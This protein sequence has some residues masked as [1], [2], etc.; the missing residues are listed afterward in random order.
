M[1]QPAVVIVA[2]FIAT[3]PM[4]AQAPE[5]ARLRLVIADQTGAVIPAA[6]V[7]V[8]R[9]S[10]ESIELTSDERGVVV[11]PALD[12]GVA[13]IRVEFLGFE[14]FGG[15]VELRRGS[16]TETITLTVEG[17][18]EEVIVSDATVDDTRG[19]SMSTTL[20]E[21]E[22]DALPDDPEE[23]MAILQDMAG[24]G[25]AT[26]TMDGFRGGRLPT[27]DEIRSIRFR[28]NSFSAENHDAGRTGVD[29]VTRP[30]SDFSGNVNLGLKD[31]ALNARNAMARVETPEGERNVQLGLRGPIVREKT[32][33]RF[34]AQVNSAY[35][36]NTIIA[37]DETGQS[38]GAQVRVP[39]ERR[40]LNANLDHV[41]TSTQMLRLGY[42]H[43]QNDARNQGLGSFDLPE[44]ASSRTSSND[45]VRA[46]VQGLVGR[47]TLNELRLQFN[48][49]QSETVSLTTG[50]TIIV[51]DA[52]SRG[53]AGAGNRHL[54][55][56][57]E[58]AENL[59]FTVRR[60][61]QMRVGVLLEAGRYATVD[62]QN[63]DGRFT[64]A[65]LDAFL[66]GRPLQYTQRIGTVDTA[67][68]QY[69]IGVYWQ[70][71]IRLRRTLSFSVGV[72]QEWQSH[73]GD[74][75]NV[76]P[77][78]GLTWNPQGRRTTL[79]G[80]YG[81]F[82]DWYD[83]NLHDQTLRVNGVAQRDLLIL[84]PGFPDPFAGADPVIL[85]GGRIQADPGLRLPY[86][87]QAS[88]GLERPLV[89]NVDLQVSYQML[90][91]RNQLRARDVN[92]PVDGLRPEPG[93]GTVTQIEST[94][95]SLSD[96]LSVQ[97]RLRA[98]RSRVM[99]SVTYMVGRER[100]HSNGALSLP[101][102]SLDPDVDWGPSGG[103]VRHRLRVQAQVPVVLGMRATVRFAGQS[104]APYTMTTGRD[105]NLDGVV[106][107]RPAGI[108]RNSLRG[109]AFWN[110]SSLRFSRQLTL[111]GARG[112]GSGGAVRSRYSV[113]VFVN[114]SNPLNRVIPQAYSG[115]VL[116]PF[117]Q[118]ATRVQQARRV[119]FGLGFRF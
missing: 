80:G 56:T 68:T 118:R 77:R 87:H 8:T 76:M 47:T 1:R 88:I 57:I 50:P 32:S 60:R 30:S 64:F 99:T 111:G 92:T 112:D 93:V 61:H 85:P 114:A 45:M 7:T 39:T 72:R 23:L 29:I 116:S 62:E 103:D 22:I 12:P 31:D 2:A 42:Q 97:A 79:R 105:D 117:F 98:P 109:E 18:L 110:I 10:G 102:N 106:N 83:S 6:S 107:D 89:R 44:R 9:P 70:D 59:D 94:G 38:L 91:G 14:P 46:Q 96:R 53:S 27:R 104:G 113:E 108:G 49:Q 75:V 25:G 15:A 48:R 41:L 36:S 21:E 69:Q 95:R 43:S 73:V 28:T 3:A 5:P 52:F 101:S 66:N 86:V 37:V 24:P 17:F 119:D 4:S 54:T 13:Q 40:S 51:Q 65:S 26:F 71:E 100:N 16:T 84:N 19:N 78:F 55:H 63:K 67:F 90:R 34:N 58:L 115:N 81:V 33:V 74:Q 11:L 82:Y 20:T 35:Q